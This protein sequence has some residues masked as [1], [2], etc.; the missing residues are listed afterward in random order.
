MNKP[1]VRT[2]N[3]RI[4]HG[5]EALYSTTAHWIV[6]AFGIVIRITQFFYNRSLTEGEAA[7]ALNIVERSY[8]NLLKPLDYFQ[9]A[10]VGFLFIERCAVNVLGTSEYAL[11]LFPLIA[12]IVAFFLFYHCAKSILKTKAIPVA[13]ILRSW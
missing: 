11:R 9:A 12:G 4:G 5:V 1:D 8:L 6:I 13:L 2:G 3:K 10:P 7:L